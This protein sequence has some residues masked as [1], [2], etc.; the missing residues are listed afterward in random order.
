MWSWECLQVLTIVITGIEINDAVAE[1]AGK[2]TGRV[3]GPI[4]L[5]CH[6]GRSDYRRLYGVMLPAYV[7]SMHRS[8]P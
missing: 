7:R 6:G 4:V 8:A 2:A 1:K 3:A 5:F